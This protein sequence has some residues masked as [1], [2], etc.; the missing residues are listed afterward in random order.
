MTARIGPLKEYQSGR[1]IFRLSLLKFWHRLIDFDFFQ[2]LYFQDIFSQR[3]NFCQA[4]VTKKQNFILVYE[5][6]GHL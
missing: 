5:I 4:K 6:T 1:F 2:I 3:K